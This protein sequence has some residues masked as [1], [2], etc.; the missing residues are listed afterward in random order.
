MVGWNRL[1][2][3]R[4]P[5]KWWQ[6]SLMKRFSRALTKYRKNEAVIRN[7]GAHEGRAL[8]AKQAVVSPMNQGVL[9]ALR[10]SR[11][12]IANCGVYVISGIFCRANACKKVKARRAEVASTRSAQARNTAQA[13]RRGARRPPPVAETGR[14]KPNEAGRATSELASVGGREAAGAPRTR[15]EA[16]S[17]GAE[18]RAS[19]SAGRCEGVGRPC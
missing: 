5:A 4:R 17:A 18:H 12:T 15:S 7:D 1:F 11:T 14:S 9:Q 3:R 13:K 8:C 6:K 10:R 19:V 16:K 2:P